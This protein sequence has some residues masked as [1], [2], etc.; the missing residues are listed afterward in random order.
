MENLIA[1]GFS[2]GFRV[3]VNAALATAIDPH[4]G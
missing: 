3:R 2:L 4:V 1:P